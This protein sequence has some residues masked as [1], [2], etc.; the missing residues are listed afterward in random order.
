[1][2][3]KEYIEQYTLLIPDAGNL[4]VDYQLKQTITWPF[5]M[6]TPFGQNPFF[7]FYFF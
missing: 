2:F 4:T 7:I 1:M 3:T 6:L 5:F